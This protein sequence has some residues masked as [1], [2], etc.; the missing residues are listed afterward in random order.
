MRFSLSLKAAILLDLCLKWLFFV[1]IRSYQEIGTFIRE[2]PIAS[3]RFDLLPSSQYLSNDRCNRND[4]G[5]HIR[6]RHKRLLVV[7]DIVTKWDWFMKVGGLQKCHSLAA[8]GCRSS[9]SR[10]TDPSHTTIYA[11]EKKRKVQPNRVEDFSWIVKLS[12]VDGF[13]F[14]LM[15]FSGTLHN[16]KGFRLVII[17]VRTFSGCSGAIV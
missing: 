14:L 7:L 1:G 16:F 3:N 9:R 8:L 15:S 6:T 12:S 10:D 5:D 17:S 13:F 2:P 11:L 4:R